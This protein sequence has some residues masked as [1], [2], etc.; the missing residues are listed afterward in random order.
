[1]IYAKMS[2]RHYEEFVAAMQKFCPVSNWN[3]L[4]ES[5]ITLMKVP[6]GMFGKPKIYAVSGKLPKVPKGMF[7]KPKIYDV[8]GKLPKVLQYKEVLTKTNGIWYLHL[9]LKEALLGKSPGTASSGYN[10]CERCEAFGENVGG[11]VRFSNL[12][13]PVR[14]DASWDAYTAHNGDTKFAHRRHDS[15]FNDYG[16]VSMVHGFALDGMHIVGGGAVILGLKT[17]FGIHKFMDSRVRASLR[18]NLVLVNKY[19]QAWSS[20]TLLEVN[21]CV[22]TIDYIDQWKMREAHDCLMYHMIALLGVPELRAGL[23]EERVDAFMSFVYAMHLIGHT[24]HE[25]PS[26]RDVQMAEKLFKHYIE[27]FKEES[28]YFMTPKNHVLIHLAQEAFT[29]PDNVIAMSVNGNTDTMK[30]FKACVVRDLRRDAVSRKLFIKVSSF[31]VIKPAQ[32]QWR[33]RTTPYP[34]M[35]KLGC[36]QVANLDSVV[37]EYTVD[38]VVGRLKNM[39]WI[40]YKDA[41][42][43]MQTHCGQNIKFSHAVVNSGQNLPDQEWQIGLSIP[44]LDALSW[45][46]PEKNKK[47]CTYLSPVFKRTDLLP[48]ISRDLIANET[49][50]VGHVPAGKQYSKQEELIINKEKEGSRIWVPPS[51]RLRIIA[52]FHYP[53]AMGHSRVDRTTYA[54]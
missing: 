15:P 53:P 48:Y 27:T 54:L 2:R 10:S 34:S 46:P 12:D 45:F 49:E 28:D 38:C 35:R 14:H 47:L 3:E 21:R 17:L 37:E 42:E 40:E 39:Y 5:A 30:H 52:L 25:S 16:I 31:L 4:P 26:T 22:R 51:L 33:S 19:L 41:W 23:Q 8:S 24:T 32:Q 43:H 36:Y 1:M 11:C 13:A 50:K 18:V 7:G 20:H 44:H 9:G 29:Y 6:E